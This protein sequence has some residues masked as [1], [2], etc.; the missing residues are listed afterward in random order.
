MTMKRCLFI[1]VLLLT[2]VS[3]WCQEPDRR[4]ITPVQPA[5]NTTLPPARGTDEEVI[6][7]FLSGDTL[8][9]EEEARRDSLR[10]AYKRYPLLTDITVGL[11]FIDLPLMA[12]GQDYASVDVHATLN[13]W[14]RLQPVLEMGIGWGKNAPEDLNFSYRAKP[15]PYFKVGAN[16]NFLFKS[17]PRYQAVLGLRLGYSTFGYEVDVDYYNAYWRDDMSFSLTGQRSHALWGEAIAGLRVGIWKAWSLGWT[18]RYHAVF[19]Y[20]KNENGK[21]WFIPGYGPRRGNLGF[22]FSVAYTLPLLQATTPHQ[23]KPDALPV[24]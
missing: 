1:L 17:E 12:F 11:N 20:G 5:T 16:Y 7:R 19:N 10:R 3:A 2:A 15:S 23:H 18:L 8:A 21:P 13:M 22:T 14:N 9:A 4:H 6:K 24:Q